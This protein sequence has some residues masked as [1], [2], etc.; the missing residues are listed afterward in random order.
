[1]NTSVINSIIKALEKDPD[2]IDLR[3]HLVELMMNT[4]KWHDALDQ[5]QIVLSKKPGFPDA[6]EA[7]VKSGK[8]LGKDDLVKEYERILNALE[9]AVEEEND[10]IGLD[11]PEDRPA[12]ESDMPAEEDKKKVIPLKVIQGGVEGIG[13]SVEREVIRLSDV[14]GMEE[15]KRRL[16]VAFLG[17]LKNPKLMKMYKKS[18]R[19]GLLLYGPPGCGKT[20]IARATAGE[21]GA[22][23]MSVGLADILD[24]YLGQSERNLHEVFETARRNAPCVLFFD[25]VDALGRKRSLM[26]ASAGRDVVNQFLYEMDSIEADNQ[27][28]FIMAAT[29]HPWDVDTALRRPGRFD[30]ML[31]VLPPDLKARKEMLEKYFED[32]PVKDLDYDWMAKTTKGFSGADIRHLC[33]SAAEM[34]MEESITTGDVRHIIKKDCK[35]ALKEIKPST[36]PWFETAKNYAMFSNEGGVYDELLQYLRNNKKI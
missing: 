17:P 30:R 29:N 36:V 10:G 19:G 8:E 12:D 34:A 20:Y 35:K 27:S 2:N 18:L 9:P 15:V 6:L 1:M 24:M 32:R 14:A 22:K 33:E 16:N 26:R 23:F 7:A 5:C 28:L 21:L 3:M 4:D 25:E 13:I 11:V 31:L